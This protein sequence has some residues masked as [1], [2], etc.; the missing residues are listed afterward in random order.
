MCQIK[1]LGV[2]GEGFTHKTKF[3][4]VCVDDVKITGRERVGRGE[5]KETTERVL[6]YLI[7][8]FFF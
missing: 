6:V 3:C 8:F 1:N 5:Q 7:N 4:G 2:V